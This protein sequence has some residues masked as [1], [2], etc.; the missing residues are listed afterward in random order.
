YCRGRVWTGRA[1]L[2]NHLADKVGNVHSAIE[3]ARAKA[4]LAST[5][6]STRHHSTYAM[7]MLQQVL[8]R[9]RPSLADDSSFGWLRTW[10][11]L[12]P[13]PRWLDFVVAHPDQP[14]AL[15]P[16]DVEPK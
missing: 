13:L 5:P 1:A 4:G 14:L 8:K 10:L 9:V 16:F 2:S 15:L 7:P 3:L 11:R 12:L 6:V